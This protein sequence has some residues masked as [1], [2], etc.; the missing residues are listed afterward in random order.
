MIRQ[1]FGLVMLLAAVAAGPVVAQRGRA[2]RPVG[3]PARQ[4]GL[5]NPLSNPAFD[6]WYHHAPTYWNGSSWQVI[7]YP[8]GS[9]YLPPHYGPGYPFVPLYGSTAYPVPY[10]VPVSPVT[11][12]PF[13]TSD[14]HVRVPVETARLFIA[15]QELPGT[16]LD[17]HLSLPPLL[18][19]A[20][21]RQVALTCNWTD[22][23][24]N[25][26]SVQRLVKLDGAK[27]GSADFR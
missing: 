22:A 3:L 24:G 9:P 16:G 12:Q 5:P 23:A 7:P 17:R 1:R 10:A 6:W 14:I 15:G 18:D 8:G 19:P 27:H 2:T 25:P 26:H 11:G 20:V 13:T 21:T 4:I